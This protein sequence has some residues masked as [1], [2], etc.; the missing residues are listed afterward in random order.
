MLELKPN[1]VFG[2]FVYFVIR[3]MNRIHII[4]STTLVFF[5]LCNLILPTSIYL[6]WY[7]SVTS[8]GAENFVGFESLGPASF[9]FSRNLLT[10]NQSRFAGVSLFILCCLIF[11][12]FSIYRG[13]FPIVYFIP[14][15]A[16]SFPYLHYLDL[17]IAL[18]F[19]FP[20]VIHST[21]TRFLA[22]L[23]FFSIFLPMPSAEPLKIG[24]CLTL[25]MTFL[26]IYYLT[27]D[28]KGIVFL[29][30]LI[31]GGY[32]LFNY[33][34]LWT[35]LSGPQLQSTTVFKSWII[36]QATLLLQLSKSPKSVNI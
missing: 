31:S 5:T 29:S 2:I 16:L 30:F 12:L 8:R 23:V 35:S 28:K 10:E 32:L 13:S 7:Q 34:I 11:V 14:L 25:T 27:S 36:I 17:A 24:V 9:L 6:E 1:L 15:V 18:P 20:V 26:L 21:R 4:F 19:L 33:L 3:N 22:P